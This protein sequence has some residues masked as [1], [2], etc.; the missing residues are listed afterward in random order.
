MISEYKKIIND[1]NKN[2]IEQEKLF[3]SN[4][5]SREKSIITD[6]FYSQI[7]AKFKC[8]YKKETYCFQTLLDYSL[9]ISENTKHIKIEELLNIYFN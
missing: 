9:L 1:N 7:I 8:Q 4:F 6:L 5:Q 2:K 3:T